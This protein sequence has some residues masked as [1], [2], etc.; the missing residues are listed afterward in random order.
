MKCIVK[1]HV[2]YGNRVHPPGAV[3][4]VPDAEAEQLAS[5]GIVQ[6]VEVPRVKSKPRATETKNNKPRN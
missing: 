1:K 4:D 6:K 2:S 3:I 5:S